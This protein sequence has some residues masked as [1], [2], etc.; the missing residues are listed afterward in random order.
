MKKK[1]LKIAIVALVVG[2]MLLTYSFMAFAS[3]GSGYETYKNAV[4]ST[5]LA[6][7]STIDAQF[8]VTDN[9]NTVLTGTT[10][11]KIDNGN[12]STKTNLNIM[13]LTNNV[14]SSYDNGN[15]ITEVNGKYYS[16]SGKRFD[17]MENLTSSSSTVKL[18][19]VLADTLV[20]NVKNDF[21]ENGQTISVNLQG[22]Q[23]PELAKLAISAM[24]ENMDRI[25]NH[26]SVD[27]SNNGMASMKNIMSLIPTLSNIDVKS[28]GLTATVDGNLLKSNEF[29]IA[30]SGTDT[31]GNVHNINLTVDANIS[32]IGN[33]KIDTIDTTGKQVITVNNAGRFHG[34]H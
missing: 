7:N 12:F 11:K 8:T 16:M 13:G 21:I 17:K 33:T 4:V 32:N 30:I 3:S 15:L 29:N 26:S 19:E 9:G 2:T 10:T 22:S 1:G 28:I 14:E 24:A 6:K 5:L 27:I 23:I 31:S 34:M 20:G 18:A 25:K